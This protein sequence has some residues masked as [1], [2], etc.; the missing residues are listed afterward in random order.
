MTGDK[1]SAGEAKQRARMG[2]SPGSLAAAVTR[3]TEAELY[4][5]GHSRVCATEL[6]CVR[7]DVFCYSARE[8]SVPH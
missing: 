6:V 7:S 8:C 5:T 3:C 2:K 4:L 1:P